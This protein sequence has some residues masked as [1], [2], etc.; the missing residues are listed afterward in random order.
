MKRICIY[1]TYD[2]QKVVD[3]YIGY[4]LKELKICSDHLSVVCNQKEV[5]RGGETLKKFADEIFYRENIGFDAGGFKDAL[6]KYIGW[7]RILEYDELILANDSMFGP[8][9]SMKDIF[10]EMDLKPVD[11]WGLSIHGEGKNNYVGYIHEHVQSFFLVIRSKML[12]DQR[13]INYWM[14]MPYFT[15]FKETI[16]Q[17][18]IRFSRYFSGLG[19]TYDALADTKANDSVH[20]SNNYSQYALIS[21]EMLKKRNF[22]FLKKQPLAE[23]TLY[24]QTQ[25]NL[26][27]AIDYINAETDY[28]VNLI[29]DNIIRV[30]NM[31]DLQQSLHL[32]YIVSEKERKKEAFGN[33][34]IVIFVS[35]KESVEY[36]QEYLSELNVKYFVNIFAGNRECLKAYCQHG[37]RCEEIEFDKIAEV[38]VKFAKYDY[39]CVLHDTDIT[40][41]VNYSCVGKSY[42]YNIWVNLLKDNKHVE[43]VMDY[44]SQNPRLGFLAPPQPN[45]GDYFGEY[46]KGWDQKYRRVKRVV[47]NLELSCQ[48]SEEKAPFRITENFWIRGCIL[49]KLGNIKKDEVSELPYL[50]SFLAQDAGYY[51][52]IIENLD[53]AS[54]NEVNLQNYL[55]YFANLVRRTCGDFSNYSEMWEKI[56]ICALESFCGKYARIMVYGAG[57]EAR[58]HSG[59][60][61]DIDV[62]VV[63]DDQNKQPELNG[64][65]VKY[66]SEIEPSD[67]CGIVLFMNKRN[68]M[69]VIPL[70]REHG[71]KN[72]FCM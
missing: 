61:P 13:F 19:Y 5:I 71:I 8:F 42:L 41:E 34:A 46:G 12:H 28:D 54:M 64:I 15:S 55:N 37:L 65:K 36:V 67:D 63:S 10:S 3:Q 50:W 57:E 6:C 44:F 27:Q 32:Q 31:A 11:F 56:R 62:Y 25:Q 58:I 24:C 30:Y 7:N 69:Q 17:H 22:P 43:G 47:E 14:T 33:I 70:L 60:I 16:I 52:G 35:Y 20:C 68:Q 2:R 59:L 51:S 4:M 45:F 29:W 23:N 66:L 18:E 40:S 48:I 39:V 9:R 26:R 21:F 53:Y 1:L 72:Y 49:K 38:L